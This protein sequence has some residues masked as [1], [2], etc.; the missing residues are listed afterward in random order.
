M[1]LRLFVNLDGCPA[2]AGAYVGPVV[3]ADLDHILAWLHEDFPWIGK[4]LVY[5]A[6]EFQNN[7]ALVGFI[8][9]AEWAAR[10][11]PGMGLVVEGDCVTVF[12]WLSGGFY[13]TG[14]ARRE[15]L[16]ELGN[17]NELLD[18]SRGISSDCSDGDEFDED[19]AGMN[20]EA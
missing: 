1:D 2:G 4:D 9:V 19:M 15:L 18:E 8:S 12:N 11:S 13:T 5:S 7:S 17:A 20:T 6:Y 14:C 16:G 10:N 3:W